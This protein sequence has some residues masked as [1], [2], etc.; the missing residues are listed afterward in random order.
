[1]EDFFYRKNSKK[2]YFVNDFLSI[3]VVIS[4]LFLILETVPNLQKFKNLFSLIEYVSA[5]IFL[6]EYIGRIIG[7]KNKLSYIFSFFGFID[8]FSILPTFIGLNNFLAL[9]SLRS[10]RI[11]RFLRIL[12]IT[13]LAKIA[14]NK[15][16]KNKDSLSIIYINILIY[17]ST[18]FFIIVILG[19]LLYLSEHKQVLFESIPKS[20]VYVFQILLGDDIYNPQISIS[21]FGIFILFCARFFGFIFLGFLVSIIGKIVSYT[22]LGETINYKDVKSFD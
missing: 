6:F 12:R 5:T 10:L 11:L 17:F 13:K 1:M 15:I 16:H 7:A 2:F 8:L 4:L 3:V 9:K 19:S 20:M 21:G 14:K 22:L 18:L